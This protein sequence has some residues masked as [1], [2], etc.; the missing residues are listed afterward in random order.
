MFDTQVGPP[1]AVAPSPRIEP[2][3]VADT[4]TVLPAGR[5]D[6]EALQTLLSG[7]EQQSLF[8]RFLA[9]L[10]HPSAD[11]ARALL[12][13]DATHGALMAWAVADCSPVGHVCWAVNADGHAEIGVVVTE[14]WQHRGIGSALLGAAATAAT[15]AGATAVQLDV[16]PE[17]QRVINLLRAA[18]PGRRPAYEPGMLTWLL[19]TPDDGR[20]WGTPALSPARA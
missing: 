17:N 12:T 1:R 8:F 6:T 18:F 15:R 14:R 20:P 3:G 7:L 10:F 2:A 19:P 16:H 11:H 13:T 5:D 4:V 9:G